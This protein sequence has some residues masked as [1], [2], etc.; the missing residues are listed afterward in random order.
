MDLTY[1]KISVFFGP[2]DYAHASLLHNVHGNQKNGFLPAPNDMSLEQN[3]RKLEPKCFI[4]I[5]QSMY[6]FSDNHGPMAVFER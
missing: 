1:Q 2:L 3:T 4:R 5:F 6:S